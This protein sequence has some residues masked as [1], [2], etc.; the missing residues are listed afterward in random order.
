MVRFT[1]RRH[2]NDWVS[3]GLYSVNVTSKLKAT[4]EAFKH[5]AVLSVPDAYIAWEQ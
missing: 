3:I 5:E 2:L 4:K 1:K